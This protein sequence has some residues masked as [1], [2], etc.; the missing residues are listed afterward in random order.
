MPAGTRG[1]SKQAEKEYL[2]RLGSSAWEQTKPFSHAGSDTLAESVE[3]LHD[4][5]VALMAL[6]PSPDDLILDVGAG[7]C[8]VSDL[9]GRLNRRSVAVDI[10]HDMLR[11]G[12]ARPEGSHLQAVTGDL[13]C[14]PFRSGTFQKAICLNAI[15]HVPNIPAAVAELGR[16]LSDDGVAV[17]S[18]PGRGHAEAAESVSAMRDFGVLEQ[19]VLIP[20]FAR[21]CRAAGFRDVRLKTLSYAIPHAA[22]DLRAEQ[23]ESWS[24]PLAEKRPIRALRKIG[25]GVLE[26]FGVGKQGVLFDE[27]F[28]T[29]LLQ[30][31]RRAMENHPII[32]ASKSPRRAESA[33][34][35]A[36]AIAV[37]ADDRARPGALLAVRA[38]ID[39]T[40]PEIWP[41]A[42]QSGTGHVSFGVQLLDEAGRLIERNHH[43]VPLPHDV[44]PQTAVVLSFGCPVPQA[45]GNYMLKFDMVAEGVTW[46][47]A[48]GSQ[49][50]TK[51]LTV[52]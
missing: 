4:F 2:A 37:H 50:V 52:A 33:A 49:V 27:T 17:F 14:L 6:Q 42:S 15:H 45:T 32:V 11:A 20:D 39:N 28:G 16:V 43:R 10:S 26:F 25:R 40:G 36:A 9:L 31:L 38:E 13:E 12:R 47:E 24:L 48:A 41:A 3:L 30:A 34:P 19:D 5:A 7:G 35:R 29:S 8:W 51:K 46:F 21:A 44:P 1:T 18:E 23:W 22:F